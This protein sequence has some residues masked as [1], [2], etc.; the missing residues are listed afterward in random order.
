MGGVCSNCGEP[1]DD[2]DVFCENCGL[3]FLTGSLPAPPEPGPATATDASGAAAAQVLRVSCD[4]A[5][6]E[7]MDT[8][9]V[10]DYPDPEPDPFSVTILGDTMLVGR[11][12]PSQGIFPD[13][14]LVDDP[15]AS[16]RHA[17]LRRGVDGT[18]TVTDLGSTNGTYLGDSA[19]AIVADTPTRIPPGV[20]VYVGAWTR[21][22]LPDDH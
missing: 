4:R 21:L 20:P 8:D 2:S 9:D 22:D 19:E 10:L 17:L 12:R 7:R 15:A 16:T 5:F 18:W 13:I 14:D 1:H 6:H 11:Q 3:D